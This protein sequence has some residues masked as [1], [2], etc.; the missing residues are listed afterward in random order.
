MDVNQY[1]KLVLALGVVLLLMWLFSL[2]LRKINHAQS[3]ISGGNNRLKIV[4]QR[5]IDPKH[6]VAIVRCDDKDHLVLLS[7]NGNT[8][9]KADIDAPKISVNDLRNK[10]DIPVE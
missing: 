3:G 5:M 1:I 8:V 6:K 7:Q 10:K 4:E 2:I 9:I